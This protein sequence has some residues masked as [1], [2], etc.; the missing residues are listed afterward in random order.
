[1]EN[2]KKV[3]KDGKK[4]KKYEKMDKNE[5]KIKRWIKMKKGWKDGWKWKKD[6]KMDKNENGVRFYFLILVHKIKV[7]GATRLQSRPGDLP[8]PSPSVQNVVK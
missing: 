4:W 6:D 2:M 7:R 8:S 5:K 1:M 3:W